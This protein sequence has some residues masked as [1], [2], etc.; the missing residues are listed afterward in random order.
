MRINTHLSIVTARIG[1]SNRVRADLFDTIPPLGDRTPWEI[2]FL[3]RDGLIDRRRVFGRSASEA[4]SK[5]LVRP[6]AVL[7]LCRIVDGI[8]EWVE[9]D[10]VGG[11]A[12]AY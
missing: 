12:D 3:G 8:C 7:E 5:S 6:E 1:N 4:L 11:V 9:I 2:Y 10:S